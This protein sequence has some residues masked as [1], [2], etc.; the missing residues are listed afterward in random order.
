MTPQTLTRIHAAVMPQ[1]DERAFVAYHESMAHKAFRETLN[2]L[3][4]ANAC[5]AG[6]DL[7]SAKAWDAEAMKADNKHSMSLDLILCAKAGGL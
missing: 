4:H 5:R 2:C 1:A 7:E 6:G 3:K